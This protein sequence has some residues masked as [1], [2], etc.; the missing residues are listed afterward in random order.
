MIVCFQ[1][2]AELNILENEILPYQ[3][4]SVAE[5]SFTNSTRNEGNHHMARLTHILR[6]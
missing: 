1:S 2:Q 6:Q 5:Q 3:A 4:Q